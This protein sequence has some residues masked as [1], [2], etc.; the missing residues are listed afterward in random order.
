MLGYIIAIIGLAIAAPRYINIIINEGFLQNK[1]YEGSST[2]GGE[3]IF[4]P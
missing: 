2:C 1:R 4:P 3:A